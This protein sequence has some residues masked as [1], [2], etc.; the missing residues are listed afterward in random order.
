MSE[1]ITA[2]IWELS[3]HDKRVDIIQR[4][5]EGPTSQT[6]A[7]QRPTDLAR[8]PEASEQQRE[9]F[10][11]ACDAEIASLLRMKTLEKIPET[12]I[13]S[14]EG[15]EILP[16]RSVFA[17]KLDSAGFL[18]RYKDCLVVREDRQLTC[19]NTYAATMSMRAIQALLP[20]ATAF[21]YKSKQHDLVTAYSNA[22]LDRTTHYIQPPTSVVEEI[23]PIY[24]LLRALYGLKQ[25]PLLWKDELSA[26]LIALGFKQVSDELCPFI[27]EDGLIA[28][29]FV[30][31]V[32]TLFL[33]QHEDRAN[34]LWD[35]IMKRYPVRAMQ[36][37]GWFLATRIIHDESK[38]HLHASCR[39]C[40]PLPLQDE[41]S[42][43]SIPLRQK[44][45]PLRSCERRFLC[46]QRWQ[47]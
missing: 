41:A 22:N 25:S 19:D 43:D 2:P 28:F 24:H 3:C 37:L 17:C 36:D 29:L 32:V 27:R 5:S 14:R 4:A 47:T 35:E 30:D 23:V 33:P 20:L 40:H 6:R 38:P 34:A 26:T 16:T 8:R 31:D 12:S 1:T 13:P 9:G 45:W 21:G 42:S 11:Q 10:K 15:I 46:R 18:V 7:S 44:Y 39:P